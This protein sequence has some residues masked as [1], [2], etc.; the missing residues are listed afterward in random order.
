MVDGIMSRLSEKFDALRSRGERALIP[1][2]SAGYPEPRHTVFIMQSL[3]K[4]GA[5]IIELG[6]PF[7]DPLADGPTIQKSSAVALGHGVTLQTVLDMVRE[8]RA[9]GSQ[10]PVVLFGAYNPYFHYG[11]EKFAVAAREAGAD[12]VLIADLPA[13]DADEAAPILKKE[14]LDL[15]CLIAPTSNLERKKLICKHGSG[16][17]Y[18]I[19][20]KGVTGAR[21][22]QT[23]ELNEAMAD[24]RSCTNIPVAVGFGISS[25]EQAAQVGELADGVIVGS[26]LIDLITR[27]IGDD[28]ALYSAVENYMRELKQA[29]P[30]GGLD[31]KV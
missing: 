4:G 19:S 6:V 23:F 31:A 27:N 26:A 30:V 8:F 25:P 21:Q 1:Y 15:I 12:G 17:L 24:I 2:L 7:S 9:S 22:N 28:A 20:V 3:E 18:Y 14:G 13:D 29:L 5:D 16:F 10:V 11:F